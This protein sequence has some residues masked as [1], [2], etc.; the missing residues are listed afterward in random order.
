M[1]Q[2]IL[3][4]IK[5]VL[6][7]LIIS[8][9]V[10][11]VSANWQGPTDVPPKD[12]TAEPINVTDNLQTKTGS[13]TVGNTVTTNKICLGLNCI[14]SWPTGGGGEGTNTL[15]DVVGGIRN[16]AGPTGS[17][18]YFDTESNVGLDCPSGSVMT[19]FGTK[20]KDEGGHNDIWIRCRPLN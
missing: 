18:I 16:N 9:G 20:N 13:L 3:K 8:V 15:G 14:T 2:Q 1:K 11:Y 12:N 17:T 19:G 5:I 4:S 10:S 6:L 7:A